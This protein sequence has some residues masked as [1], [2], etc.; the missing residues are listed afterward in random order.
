MSEEIKTQN[1]EKMSDDFDIDEGNHDD[2]PEETNQSTNAIQTLSLGGSSGQDD[3]DKE[4]PV[5]NSY[6]PPDEEVDAALYLIQQGASPQDGFDQA[7]LRAVVKKLSIEKNQ[8]S[9]EKDYLRAEKC[10]RLIKV[11]SKA[12]DVADFSS[13][14]AT[15]ISELLEKKED[16]QC[17]VDEINA[18][19]DKTF[20]EFELVVQEKSKELLSKH[21]QQLDEFDASIPDTLPPQFQK[22]S[23]EYLLLRKKEKLLAKNQEFVEAQKLK[24]KADKLE[25][26]ENMV[27]FMKHREDFQFRRNKLIEQQNKQF[28]LFADWV[29]TKR[30]QMLN[31]REKE[32]EGP[33]KRLDHYSQIIETLEKKGL[34]PNPVHGFTTNRVNRKESIRAVRTAAMTPLNRLSGKRKSR[35][36]P[37]YQFRPTSALSRRGIRKS[38]DGKT[39]PSFSTVTTNIKS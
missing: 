1:N 32:M 22:H 19:W 25:S 9:V 17:I 35:E 2:K 16:S 37:L 29:N 39:K 36:E 11:I 24:K 21:T 3:K 27:Q 33:I 12:A 30:H 15:T 5:I 10:S 8:A 26:D 18:K 34:P 38:N 4:N 20:E 23:P 6:E 31:G 7:T 14:A 28:E 13:Q